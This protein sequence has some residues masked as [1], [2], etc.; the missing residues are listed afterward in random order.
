M[1]NLLFYKWFNVKLLSSNVLCFMVYTMFHVMMVLLSMTTSP[2]HMLALALSSR[3]GTLYSNVDPEYRCGL[4]KSLVFIVE[5]VYVFKVGVMLSKI[6]FD[7][8]SNLKY[9]FISLELIILE[10]ESTMETK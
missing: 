10:R 1:C 8:I 7:I 3:E 4:I 5:D 2:K 6:N 9:D